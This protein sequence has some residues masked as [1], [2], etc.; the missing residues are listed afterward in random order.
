MSE[1]K[2]NKKGSEQ[3]K[4]RDKIDELDF[5]LRKQIEA[6]IRDTEEYLEDGFQSN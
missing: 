4:E 1:T 6:D 3:K 5:I 2:D